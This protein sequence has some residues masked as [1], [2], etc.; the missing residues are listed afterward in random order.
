MLYV[1][2]DAAEAGVDAVCASVKEKRHAAR[3]AAA[4]KARRSCGEAAGRVR[5]ELGQLAG[6]GVPHGG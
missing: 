1:L 6:L 5:G 2:V 3:A 4:R